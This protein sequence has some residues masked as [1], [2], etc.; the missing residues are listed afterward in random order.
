MIVDVS[1][2]VKAALDI[3]S[4]LS[5]LDVYASALGKAR[6]LDESLWVETK[7]RGIVER[8]RVSDKKVEA[9]AESKRIEAEVA[10]LTASCMV[11][12]SLLLT[13]KR[14]DWPPVTRLRFKALGIPIKH[15]NVLSLTMEYLLK[16]GTE[17][18]VHTHRLPKQKM[19]KSCLW[20]ASV[21]SRVTVNILHSVAG[22]E[23]AP[24]ALVLLDRQSLWK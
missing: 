23:P 19:E 3:D 1:A 13:L 18:W 16:F 17:A 21:M 20:P 24:K 22:S 4:V 9:K 6:K 5:N 14:R 12:R 11:T 8:S 7:R 15:H 10:R 2:K